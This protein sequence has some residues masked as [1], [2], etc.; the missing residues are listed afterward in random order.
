M[1]TSVYVETPVCCGFCLSF[2]FLSV[3]VRGCNTLPPAPPSHH[4]EKLTHERRPSRR[5][6]ISPPIHLTT[7]APLSTQELAAPP[8]PSTSL[9]IPPP[10]S[11]SVP[12]PPLLKA[13][14]VEFPF[15][16][17]PLF[18]TRLIEPNS[19]HYRKFVRF[20][21]IRNHSGHQ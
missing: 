4:E 13:D 17:R 10:R 1:H 14:F 16:T 2:Y 7:P 6:I 3:S 9:P 12:P 18:N 15:V 20:H 11:L 5:Q 8:F 19:N 21:K